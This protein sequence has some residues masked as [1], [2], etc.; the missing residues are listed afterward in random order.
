[1]SWEGE[2]CREWDGEGMSVTF[3]PHPF[4]SHRGGVVLSLD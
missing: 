2:Q 4:P 1:M 3:S